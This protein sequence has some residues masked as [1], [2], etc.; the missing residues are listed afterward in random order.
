MKIVEFGYAEI[1][2]KTLGA[3]PEIKGAYEDESRH[4]TIE[5]MGPYNLFDIILAPHVI[6][7][8]IERGEFIGVGI[9][10]RRQF[11]KL[12]ENIIRSASGQDFRELNG[13]GEK[14]IGIRRRRLSSY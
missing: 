1:I 8:L 13:G 7:L 4:W 3:I 10:T 11:S 2:P 9:R 6:E 12:V 5:K 14:H